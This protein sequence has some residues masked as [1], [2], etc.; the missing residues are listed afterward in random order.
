VLADLGFGPPGNLPWCRDDR[1][2]VL[3][4]VFR[5]TVQHDQRQVDR[6]MRAQKICERHHFPPAAATY[7]RQVR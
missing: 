1:T 3:M 4:T 5:K 6:A 7:E 2:I